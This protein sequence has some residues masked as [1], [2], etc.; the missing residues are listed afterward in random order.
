MI[1]GGS[2]ITWRFILSQENRGFAILHA[3]GWVDYCF[4]LETIHFRKRK[5][6]VTYC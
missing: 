6:I 4:Q 5:H 3:K 1:T 2:L